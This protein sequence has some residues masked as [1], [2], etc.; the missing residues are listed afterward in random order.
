MGHFT[1]SR[2]NLNHITDPVL[3]AK[4]ESRHVTLIVDGDDDIKVIFYQTL[5]AV[6]ERIYVDHSINYVI[7][8]AENWCSGLINCGDFTM[9]ERLRA[10]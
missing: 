6:A 8:A 2:G 10:S 5:T 9:E 7:D 1:V 4:L 3:R